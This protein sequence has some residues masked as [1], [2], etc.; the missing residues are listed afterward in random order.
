MP[1]SIIPLKATP[2]SKN[3]ASYGYDPLSLTLAVRFKSFKTGV[4]GSKVYE[5]PNVPAEK[6]AELE[7]A[8]SKGSFI[9]ANFVKTEHPF[10]KME[11]EP[12]PGPDVA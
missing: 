2:D 9:N 6:F 12:A 7:A 5:Y 3:I 11:D 4:P 8:E 1:A 10:E